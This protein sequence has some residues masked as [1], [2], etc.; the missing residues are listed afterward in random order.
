[1]ANRVGF[2]RMTSPRERSKKMTKLD[3]RP[4]DRSAH[5]A[6]KEGSRPQS[7]CFFMVTAPL[8]LP[9]LP[10]VLLAT[11][12]MTKLDLRPRKWPV[13]AARKEGVVRNQSFRF[14]RRHFCIHSSTIS[15]NSFLLPPPRNHK[16]SKSI[17]NQNERRKAVCRFR[18]R[19]DAP[20]E[21]ARKSVRCDL[22]NKHLPTIYS[23]TYTFHS[24]SLFRLQI[25]SNLRYHVRSTTQ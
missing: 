19:L 25:Q 6:K 24:I 12:R 3:L 8:V 18:L 1:M 22:L 21:P 10:S 16:I 7:M 11:E 20:T 17:A 5:A 13:H 23:F 4:W 14:Y 2:M 9:P 15:R